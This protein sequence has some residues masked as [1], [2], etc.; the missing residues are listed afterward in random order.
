MA[1]FITPS[2]QEIALME[3]EEAS[4]FK[5]AVESW[6]ISKTQGAGEVVIIEAG[7]SFFRVEENDDL[8]DSDNDDHE[9]P[10]DMSSL[11]LE[12]SP[13]TL[14]A[15]KQHLVKVDVARAESS[16]GSD[17]LDTENFGLS[18][19][20]WSDESA[21]LLGRE[22]LLT[23]IPSM[24]GQ[25]KIALLS[26]PSVWFGIQRLHELGTNAAVRVL[27]FDSRFELH[28]GEDFVFFDFNDVSAIPEHLLGSF[29]YLIAGL[30]FKTHAHCFS[31]VGLFRP[32]CC[33]DRATVCV[34]VMHRQ[35][36]RRF[37]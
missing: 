22:S 2:L 25:R 6:R 8:H 31:E 37:R 27:E 36:H 7:G 34:L 28:M 20:W 32:A 30:Y 12:L 11:E 29:D 4:E 9:S 33:L 14:A 19:F 24:S 21:E 13:E 23:P 35:V 15:L 3:E 1:N 16:A 26:A 17:P 18:Q 10:I 5:K